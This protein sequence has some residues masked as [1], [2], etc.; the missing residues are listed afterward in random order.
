MNHDGHSMEDLRKLQPTTV[1]IDKLI[2][3]EPLRSAGIDSDHVRLLMD[4]DGDL[5]P[6]LVQQSTMRVI[7]GTHRVFAARALGYTEISAYLL[8]VDDTTALLYGIAA[9]ISHGLPLSLSDRKTA[10]LRI[11]RLHPDWSDRA[12]GRACGLSGKT[13]AALRVTQES[14][15]AAPR[16]RIGLDGRARPVDG[17]TGR[18]LVREILE[19]KPNAPLR[20]VAK[21]AG[22]STG[23]VRKVR[24]ETSPT[25]GGSQGAAQVREADQP[26]RQ[27]AVPSE[28][29]EREHI[30]RMEMD[31]ERI[32]DNLRR[33]PSLR[34]RVKGR[35]LLRLLYRGP[36]LAAGSAV[37]DEIPAHCI[38]AV[39]RLTRMYAHEWLALSMLLESRARK[40]AA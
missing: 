1:A 23:T 25:A 31:P 7:D 34:Y 21:E 33:D 22:V 37:V 14:D 2:E 9:N 15:L 18:Q 28:Y 27:R 36:V 6:I 10:A 38:P 40:E 11:M 13:I 26:T 29:P 24:A 16:L 4:C 12:L 39:A 17:S 8:D 35:D 19:R 30:A 20:Q 5:P 32:L 3:G